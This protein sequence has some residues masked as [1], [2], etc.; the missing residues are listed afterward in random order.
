[1]LVD[2]CTF[3]GLVI[4]YV[5]YDWHAMKE[6]AAPA[7]PAAGRTRRRAPAPKVVSR[8]RPAVIRLTLVAGRARQP[9]PGEERRVHIR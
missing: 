9:C 6:P 1:M 4:L 8:S 3:V 7:T 5:V 2:V